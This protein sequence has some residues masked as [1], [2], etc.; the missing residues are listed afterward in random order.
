MKKRLFYLPLL[1]CF[2]IVCLSCNSGNGTRTSG[3]SKDVEL[4]ELSGY[5]YAHKFADYHRLIYFTFLDFVALGTVY[6]QPEPHRFRESR[7][8]SLDS[9]A[10]IIKAYLIDFEKYTA[11]SEYEQLRTEMI[12]VFSTYL[13]MI[14][15]DYHELIMIE[16][17]K[18]A[19]TA[20]KITEWSQKYADFQA[21][22]ENVN[23]QI[24]KILQH[25]FFVDAEVEVETGE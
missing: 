14:E 21:R 16:T 5:D 11:G 2:V 1:L 20:E 17:D 19:L 6:G 8:Y 3:E 4:I 25:E 10:N 9:A 12:E 15:D 18:N 7:L 23:L 22:W 24:N 13:S